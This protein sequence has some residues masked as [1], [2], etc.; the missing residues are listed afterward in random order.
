MKKKWMR[1]PG[2]IDIDYHGGWL[3]IALTDLAMTN[4]I[5]KLHETLITESNLRKLRSVEINNPAAFPLP[6]PSTCDQD[7]FDALLDMARM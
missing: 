3:H 5:P 4:V 6:W 2:G 7:K 1:V